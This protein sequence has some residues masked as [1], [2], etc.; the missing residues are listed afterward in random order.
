MQG[1]VRGNIGNPDLQWET[2][3]KINLGADL[4]L[5]NERV[6]LSVDALW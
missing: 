1:L 5:F 6:N 3:K 2:V 4:G